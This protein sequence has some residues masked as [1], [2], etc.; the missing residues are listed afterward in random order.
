MHGPIGEAESPRA[1]HAALGLGAMHLDTAGLDGEAPDER[2]GGRAA[3]G[4]PTAPHPARRPS[5]RTPR[6]DRAVDGTA[7]P[8]SE[9]GGTSRAAR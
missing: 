4:E 8:R 5:P 7:P 1:P 9:P 2:L 3:A 6:K